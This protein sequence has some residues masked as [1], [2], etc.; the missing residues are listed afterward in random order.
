MNNLSDE[1]I[2]DL[3][4]AAANTRR[5]TGTLTP[6]QIVS[7]ERSLCEVLARRRGASMRDR[8]HEIERNFAEDFPHVRTQADVVESLDHDRKVITRI[9]VT[10]Y[11]G[12]VKFAGVPT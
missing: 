10:T 11:A 1:D 6:E 12:F 4:C 5:G 9:E 2:V 8:L 3:L 7:V